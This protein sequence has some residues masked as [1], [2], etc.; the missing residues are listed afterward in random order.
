MNVKGLKKT[1]LL[2]KEDCSALQSHESKGEKEGG[3]VHVEAGILR[4]DLGR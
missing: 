3:R 2:K 1:N 4:M